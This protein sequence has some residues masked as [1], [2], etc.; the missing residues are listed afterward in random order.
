M[1]SATT[2]AGGGHAIS[3]CGLEVSPR[4]PEPQRPQSEPSQAEGVNRPGLFQCRGLRGG[5]LPQGP[6]EGEGWPERLLSSAAGEGLV[7][8]PRCSPKQARRGS[9]PAP[10]CPRAPQQR[11]AAS[12]EDE[13]PPSPTGRGAAPFL[14]PWTRAPAQ[15]PG[16]QP[17]ERALMGPPHLATQNREGEREM[18]RWGGEGGKP[19]S[20]ST[21]CQDAPVRRQ[22]RPGSG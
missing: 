20:L 9:Q 14:S 3:C 5:G 1:R 16:G 18:G 13:L 19:R 10:P 22:E 11:P 6:Q 15:T 8:R 7:G 12:L 17:G 2:A 21:A 4:Q